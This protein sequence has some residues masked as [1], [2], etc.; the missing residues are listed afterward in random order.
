MKR[1]PKPL[2][3]SL[4]AIAIISVCHIRLSHAA[5]APKPPGERD[6]KILQVPSMPVP[7]ARAPYT[8]PVFGTRVVRVTDAKSDLSGG[9]TSRGMKNEYSRV[10]SFNANDKYMVVR[11]INA[12]WY[13]YDVN[14]LKPVRQL[15]F[16]G[17]AEP[18][19]DA[20]DPDRLYY[21]GD[22]KLMAYNVS[23]GQSSVVHDFSRDVPSRTAFVWTKGEGSPSMD[24]RY[25]GFMADDPD[26]KPLAFLIYDLARDRIIAKRNLPP[27]APDYDHVTISPKGDYFF[28]GYEEYYDRALMKKTPLSGIGHGDIA[29]DANGR[30]VM[31]YQDTKTD[32]IS[33][34]DL[35][36]GKVTPLFGIDFSKYSK[37]FHIS[38]RAFKKPGWA[39]VSCFIEGNHRNSDWM[40]NAIFA[41]ELKP[42]GRIIRLA[43]HHSLYNPGM[44]HDYWAEPH[45][46][47]NR[48]LTRVL[49]T[50]NWGKT[51]TEQV[52][53]YMIRLP[54]NWI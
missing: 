29:L 10:Q 50:S 48:D 49:F 52:E 4:V 14:T 27:N 20:N 46:T 9:D 25:W 41:V 3:V 31:V 18:R 51:G 1:L 44:E 24:G 8:E 23:S 54:E 33:M 32:N 26:G 42:K 13:L 21:L 30:E 16:Q 45:A 53:M 11:S 40:D 36:T 7:A 47:V 19:W 39:L 34:L 2:Y 43:H 6:R 37:G 22:K 5:P 17:E 35:A 38:G 12:F 28:A 15:P